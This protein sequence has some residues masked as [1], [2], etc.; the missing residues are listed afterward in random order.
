MQ[1]LIADDEYIIREGL[2]S[3]DWASIGIS[4]VLSAATGIEAQRILNENSIDIAILDI[5]MPGI[6][7]LELADYI[8]TS[9]K[10]NNGDSFDRL[11]GI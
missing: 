1:L 10:P 9:K 7:G 6:S 2:K 4:S 3:L 11:C 5:R 8:Q